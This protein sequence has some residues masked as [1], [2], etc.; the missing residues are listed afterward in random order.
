VPSSAA[1]RLPT[2]ILVRKIRLS[3]GLAKSAYVA[4]F[5]KVFGGEAVFP[6]AEKF[7]SAVVSGNA[8]CGPIRG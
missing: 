1:I 6:R 8:D 5:T 3:A 4:Y 7:F 2:A